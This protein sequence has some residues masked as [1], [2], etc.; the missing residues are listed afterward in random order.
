IERPMPAR[1]EPHI[2]ILPVTRVGK[3]P[4]DVVPNPNRM[5]G[6]RFLLETP[7]VKVSLKN[8]VL[9]VVRGKINCGWNSER[10]KAEA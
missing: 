10:G 3:D 1:I 5:P 7:E 4:R 2:A 9:E 8:G 6:S